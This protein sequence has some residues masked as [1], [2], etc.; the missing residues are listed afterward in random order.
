MRADKAVV[1]TLMSPARPTSRSRVVAY[2]PVRRRVWVCGQRVHHGLTGAL[3]A[4]AGTVL[5]L[6]DWKDHSMWFQRGPG[7]Q[8]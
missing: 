8:S 7:H 2:D 1:E 6:H 5:M 4:I 3:L